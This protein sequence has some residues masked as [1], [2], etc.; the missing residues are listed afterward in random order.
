[1]NG[2]DLTAAVMGAI[3]LVSSYFVPKALNR[4]QARKEEEADTDLSWVSINKA[5]VTERNKLQADLEA[6]KVAHADEIAALRR[7][8]ADEM[9]A[10]ND[11]LT[12]CQGRVG[13]L[14]DELRRRPQ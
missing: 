14:Y 12:E 3:G 1:M 10:L 9:K 8:H 6:L 11:R 13:N 2:I 7:Q 5:I 4:K